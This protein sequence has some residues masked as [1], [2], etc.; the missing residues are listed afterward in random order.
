M[1]CEM[2]D[3]CVSLSCDSVV[4]GS[5]HL[6]SG[7]MVSK[8]G[9]VSLNGLCKWIFFM[10]VILTTYQNRMI[11][12]VVPTFPS[13]R[14]QKPMATSKT[15]V[16]SAGVGSASEGGTFAGTMEASW[17]SSEHLFSS[18]RVTLRISSKKVTLGEI[19]KATQLKI[20]SLHKKFRSLSFWDTY[21]P[22]LFCKISRVNRS[23]NWLRHFIK[24]QEFQMHSCERWAIINSK[25][26]VDQEKKVS[27]S[28]CHV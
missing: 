21:T 5:S 9:F 1:H 26:C 20:E 15:S 22:I 23:L 14:P 10:G 7:S 17:D 4:G 2:W 13:L 28:Q 3:A 11:L 16:A 25:T 19:D 8:S 27:G 24:K 6:V 18:E 12:Q